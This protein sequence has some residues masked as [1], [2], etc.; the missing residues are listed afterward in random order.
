MK[1]KPMKHQAKALR[2]MAEKNEFALLMD[3]GTGKTWTIFADA[4]RNYVAG[5]I[6]ALVVIAP[7]GVH[8]NWT[9][10][11][12]PKHLS[13]N[14]IGFATRKEAPVRTKKEL[15][16]AMRIFPR[17]EVAPLRV[18]A[19]HIDHILTKD[20]HALL[21]QLLMAY[22]CMLVVDESTRIKNP[23]TVR[24]TRIVNLGVLAK[25]RRIATGLIAT[26]SPSDIF[27]QF[28]FL[29]SGLLGTASYRAF[30]AEY[31]EILPREHPLYKKAKLNSPSPYADPQIAARDGNGNPIFKNLG[32]LKE[33]MAPYSFRVTKDE[34][35][36][37]PPKVY[38]TAFFELTAQQRRVYDTLEKELFIQLEEDGADK[39]SVRALNTITK[40]QQI[41]SSFVIIDGVPTLVPMSKNPR[42]ALFADLIEGHNR[43][44]IVW[45]RFNEEIDQI[46]RLLAQM[47][48]PAAE[49]RGA[50]KT[51]ARLDAIDGF[52]SGKYRAFVGNGQSG[53]IGL[54]LTA[55]EFVYYYSN[56]FNNETRRQSEDRCHRTGTNHTVVFT[57]L[58]AEDTIDERI[59]SALQR[60]SDLAAE[61]MGDKKKGR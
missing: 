30:V 47:E 34:C 35:L 12:A 16:A 43:P 19:L 2:L 52:Q 4:E 15:I 21:R 27:S 53:G 22:R 11:E 25:M 13:C 28:E 39:I 32:K 5:K 60:K 3:M 17:D 14:W 54:T 7:K 61:I 45:A 40:L 41:T 10:I 29:E 49:Y 59:A 24:T 33:L 55:A 23:K 18:F 8:T 51:A 31:T 56:D 44:F 20:G 1:T 48:I 37:L 46:M 58:A 26:N 36:D 38:K 42:L 6:D 9:R 50:T 57:D